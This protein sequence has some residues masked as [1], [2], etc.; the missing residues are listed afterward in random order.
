MDYIKYCNI[1]GLEPNFS[2]E[3]YKQRI[4]E[5]AKKYH[6]DNYSDNDAI[7]KKME[8]EMKEINAAKSYFDMIFKKYGTYHI[9][10]NPAIIYEYR[11]E[12]ITKAGKYKGHINNLQYESFSNDID[13]LVNLLN[14]K[15]RYMNNILEIEDY[16]KNFKKNIRGIYD[17]LKEKYFKDKKLYVN[18]NVNFNYE[19]SI[20]MF[21]KQLEDYYDKFIAPCKNRINEVLREYE[22]YTDYELLKSIIEQIGKN[23]LIRLKK[24]G[25]QAIGKIIKELKSD[26]KKI[27]DTHFKILEVIKKVKDYILK[28]YDGK[29]L[30][31]NGQSLDVTIY[32]RITHLEI[33]Y[34]KGQNLSDVEKELDKILELWE[35]NKVLEDNKDKIYEVFLTVSNKFYEKVREYASEGNSG[36]IQVLSELFGQFV[37]IY[38][39]LNNG[40]YD[41]EEF[42]KLDKLTF[43]NIEEDKKILTTKNEE[44]KENNDYRFKKI[45]LRLDKNGVFG[46]NFFFIDSFNDGY[47]KLSYIPDGENEVRVATVPKETFDREFMMLDTFLDRAMFS[48]RCNEEMVISLYKYGIYNL[49]IKDGSFKL[50]INERFNWQVEE[51]I[52]YHNKSY[53][54][55]QIHRWL[56]QKFREAEEKQETTA[57]NNS[58][59][60]YIRRNMGIYGTKLFNLVAS[61]N[62]N[63]YLEYKPNLV[64]AVRRLRVSLKE[65]EKDYI[66]LEDFLEKSQYIAK[67]EFYGDWIALYQYLDWIL[68]LEKDGSFEVRNNNVF[69]NFKPC[70]DADILKFKDKK[71]TI[72]AIKEWIERTHEEIKENSK[73][74]KHNK[75]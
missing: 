65:L 11:D 53:T 12:V 44:R 9:D 74:I 27:F 34:K 7:R 21:Y 3:E 50:L 14:Q 18:H 2:E 10:Y 13:Y 36:A 56:E 72:A 32:Q 15:V 25:C 45:C 17:N 73:D 33:N 20:D 51:A 66:S 8:E 30:D 35:K 59:G 46:T 58:S 1:L 24:E 48:G 23:A 31:S 57:N 63:V 52:P 28:K 29:V 62:E 75:I 61:D 68:S 55:A 43:T 40:K 60:I 64:N 16:F 42:L 70:M 4:K 26:V 47:V 49:V 6:P 5:L 22:L 69:N 54:K 41:V 37:E 39:A 38:N 19:V 71:Y 67:K